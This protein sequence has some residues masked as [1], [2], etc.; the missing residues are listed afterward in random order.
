LR[1][2]GDADRHTMAL[3]RV[4]AILGILLLGVS[5]YHQMS[6]TMSA[7]RHAFAVSHSS[8]APP[9]SINL[10]AVGSSNLAPEASPPSDAQLMVEWLASLD[11]RAGQPTQPPL[12]L[13]TTT[14]PAARTALNGAGTLRKFVR[15]AV[16]APANTIEISTLAASNATAAKAAPRLARTLPPPPLLTG[17]ARPHLTV[18]PQDLKAFTYHVMVSLISPEQQHANSRDSFLIF[19]IDRQETGSFRKKGGGITR[20]AALFSS[21]V[22]PP[23]HPP[24]PLF[25]PPGEQAAQAGDVYDSQGLVHRVHQVVFSPQR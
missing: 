24:T 1:G 6:V 21:A 4:G 14:A 9:N 13:P 12:L 20:L 5:V 17:A 3:A 19:D 23:H 11:T 25:F 18:T 22:D 7:P 16:M 10:A 2:L 15:S 8:S